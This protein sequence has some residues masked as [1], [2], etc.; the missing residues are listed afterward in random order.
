MGG[1]NLFMRLRRSE[2]RA[3]VHPV[4]RIDA[5]AAEQGLRLGERRR[6]GIFW[7]SAAYERAS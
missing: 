3:F 4:A 6:G 2:F 7:E 1:V 5:A